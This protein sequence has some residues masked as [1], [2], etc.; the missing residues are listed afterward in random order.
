[1]DTRSCGCARRCFDKLSEEK[2]QKIFNG[3]WK[4]KSFDMQTAYLC[5]CVKI[6]PVK[7]RYTGSKSRR[8]FTRDYY[9]R[10]GVCKT[11][12]LRMHDISNGRVQRALEGLSKTGGTPKPDER[13]HHIPKH[14][15]SDADISYV[16]EHI[17]SFPRQES[18]YSRKSN[19]NRQ[20]LSQTLSLTKMYALYKEKCASDGKQP[21]IYRRTFNEDF[22][23][24]FGR[25]FSSYMCH[26]SPLSLSLSPFL[27]VSLSLS[28]HYFHTDTLFIVLDQ[29]HVR[30]VMPLR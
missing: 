8:S 29:T 26:S 6:F 30:T 17:E 24:S 13:G 4:M 23:L 15:T 12:F 27:Y 21:V 18:H 11:A 28:N 10:D 25:Y 22:N 3:Y 1:M 20:Y 7:R 5:G 2:R 9:V 14:K 19:P 16:K